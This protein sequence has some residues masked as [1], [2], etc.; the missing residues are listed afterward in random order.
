MYSPSITLKGHRGSLTGGNRQRPGVD[1][2]PLS[3]AEVK[4]EW[5]YAY[6]PPVCLREVF[7]DNDTS[8]GVDISLRH[9]APLSSDTG[10]RWTTGST[11]N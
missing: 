11:L 9:P 4:N 10:L 6:N 1:R 2:T 8:A 7:R 5:S 3:S